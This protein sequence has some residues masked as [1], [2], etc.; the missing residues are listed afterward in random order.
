MA[1]NIRFISTFLTALGCA[2]IGGVFFAFSSFVMA[3]LS[4]L[5]PAQ[6]IAAMQSINVTVINRWFMGVFLG[7]GITCVGLAVGSFVGWRE[8]AAML[9][10]AG[11]LLYL[12]G[13]IGITVGLNV[14]RNDALAAI[15]P[16]SAKAAAA[17]ARYVP[18]WTDWNTVRTISALVAAGLLIGALLLDRNN[19]AI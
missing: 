18:S 19:A 15:D 8:P 3:G 4:R 9:R 10:L 6:G 17:W 13:G 5:P 12:G 2:I 16:T 1:D 7:T 11:S 14:P